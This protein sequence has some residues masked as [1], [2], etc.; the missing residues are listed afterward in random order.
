[1]SEIALGQGRCENYVGRPRLE[2]AQNITA[3]ASYN[4]SARSRS[5]G[6]QD[7]IRFK[8]GDMIVAHLDHGMRMH[9]SIPFPFNILGS[10][11]EYV[12]MR[13]LG[14]MTDA[15]WLYRYRVTAWMVDKLANR[16]VLPLINGEVLDPAEVEYMPVQTNACPSATSARGVTGSSGRG[17]TS[18]GLTARPAWGCRIARG[19]A[20]NTAIL[21]PS[22]WLKE[23]RSW[24]RI[25]VTA[26]ASA[27]HTVRTAP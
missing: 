21:G 27:M 7:W 13:I 9:S 18:P 12:L 25:G 2:F 14:R 15:D 22:T 19:S 8:E 3:A 4:G 1:M 11:Y 10:K 17:T 16:V 26:A 20:W 24:I 6:L 23:R 5:K